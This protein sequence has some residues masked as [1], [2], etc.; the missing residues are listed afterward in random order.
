[1]DT[2]MPASYF[3]DELNI[4]H[5]VE[6][7]SYLQEVALRLGCRFW[8]NPSENSDDEFEIY[9]CNTTFYDEEEED[10]VG[11]ILFFEPNS[12]LYA[13]LV[14]CLEINFDKSKSVPEFGWHIQF[15]A[16]VQGEDDAESSSRNV[17]EM[18][19]ST[20]RVKEVL[21]GCLETIKSIDEMFPN[22]LTCTFE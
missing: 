15:E 12:E 8:V 4:G 11:V 21:E 7:V 16:E 18:W 3:T 5:D 14:L 13:L 6:A 17:D 19:V 2:E 10:D 22:K 20:D 9:L 1:M